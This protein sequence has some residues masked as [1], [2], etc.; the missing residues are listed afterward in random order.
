MK[1]NKDTEKND[2]ID[3]LKVKSI[4]QRIKEWWLK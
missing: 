1:K 2:L 3:K 4:W